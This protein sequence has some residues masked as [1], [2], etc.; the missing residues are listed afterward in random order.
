MRPA[1]PNPSTPMAS[2]RDP[3]YIPADTPWESKPVGVDAVVDQWLSEGKVK[4]CLA[5]QESFA[6]T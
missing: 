3:A 6:K 2:P 4:P 5:L 1:G